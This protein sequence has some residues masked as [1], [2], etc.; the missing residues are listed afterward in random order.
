MTRPEGSRVDT[1][2]SSHWGVEVPEGA[3]PAAPGGAALGLAGASLLAACGGGGS[4]PPSGNAPGSDL[5]LADAP[6]ARFL[7][8][9]QISASESDI[10]EVK[11]KGF[12]TWLDEQMARPSSQ[13]GWDWLN[14]R[15]YGVVDA[16][17]FYFNEYAQ[18]EM[19]VWHQLFKSPDQM[20][21]RMAL[22]LSEYFVVSVD[23][24]NTVFWFRGFAM[25]HYW[26][27]LCQNAFGNF[28]QL[29]EEITLNLAMGSMLN[30]LGNQKED[31]S[32]GRLPDE[33]YAREVMQLFT[34][35]LNQL[36]PDGTPKT[37]A[38]GAPLD[39][40]TQDDVS[41]L[42]RVFTG[43]VR[44]ES[45]GFTRSPVAP[46][47]FNVANVGSTRRPMVLDPSRHSMLEK[48]F[49]GV[50]IPANTDGKTSL[51]IALDT[52]FNHPNVGPFFAR[53]MIQRLVSSHPSPAYVARVA[54][55]FNNNGAGVRGDLKAVWKAVLLDEEARGPAG[56]SSPMHGK[57]REPVLRIAQWGRT[58]KVESRRGTWKV[59]MPSGGN[60]SLAQS[61]LRAP[62]VFNFFRP[63]YVPPNTAL[64]AS[65]AT[66]PEMQIVNESTVAQYVN[67]LQ[68]VV[69]N[70]IWV[71]APETIE[72]PR[73]RTPTDGNDIV[74]DYATE[75]AMVPNA[76]A[77]L[78]RLNL[79]LCAGQL[80]PQTE[81]LLAQAV[82]TWA[83]DG[84]ADETT[85]RNMVT[86]AIVL[87]MSCPEY[88]VQK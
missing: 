38:N 81:T 7:L 45:D 24:I 76:T 53:Q 18:T 56:L 32:R 5:Q 86:R 87:V 60:Q 79:L 80:S 48:R 47:F 72:F 23:L 51:K 66:A 39:S 65:K 69:Q 77:L 8:Q 59:Q 75:M 70:G 3:T 52:L 40:Y 44:D 4:S 1:V 11:K 33:N 20:R 63:G 34:I 64:S 12:A 41:N 25:A 15:G 30:T 35:G 26:D 43:W 6:Y 27:I 78:R 57:V 42:A 74:P 85:R 10:A 68:N 19:M 71:R 17:E 61:P 46:F 37:G 21:R 83:S 84:S 13:G 58:F 73:E 55:A 54:V 29:L 50:T 62:S 16:R 2:S 9:A 49:L 22:A 28:R 88:I 14:A 67:F 31:A 82:Q 36:N